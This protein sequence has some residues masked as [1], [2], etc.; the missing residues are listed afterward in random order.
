MNMDKELQNTLWDYIIIG[1][2]VGGSTLG[3]AL[4]KKGKK[5]LFIEKGASEDFI[6]GRFPESQLSSFDHFSE[7]DL[8]LLK[9][10]GRYSDFVNEVSDKSIKRFVPL[11][12]QGLGGS[13]LIYGAALERF[14][15]EDFKPTQ[16]FSQYPN[17]SVVDWPISYPDMDSYYAQAEQLYN[18][19][20]SVDPL[21]KDYQNK[22]LVYTTL[23][24]P[25][26]SLYEYCTK[27]GLHPYRLPVGHSAHHG[28]NCK[29]C[30]AFICETGEK[31]DA[32]KV[33]VLSAIDN[34]NVFLIDCCEVKEINAVKDK[35]VSL[36]AFKNNKEYIFK[37]KN[38]VLAAGTLNTTKLLLSS[39]SEYWP[40]G[41]ANRSG[42][43]G[44]NLSRHFLDLYM[45]DINP[46]D[47]CDYFE[48]EIGLNDFY[49]YQGRK[50]GTIQSLGNPPGYKTALFE[51]HSELA[52]SH[53][54]IDRWYLQLVKWIGRP[55]MESLFRNKLCIATIMDDVSYPENRLYLSESGGELMLTYQMHEEA[56]Q[57]LAEFRKLILKNFRGLSPQ[58]HKQGENNQRLGHATGTCRMGNDPKTS[59][60][61]KF[62]RAH[63]VENLFIVDA[64][65]F[66]SGS[67]INPA[68]TIAANAL[69]VAESI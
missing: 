23:S 67:G 28:S 6:K 22:N 39:K 13:S 33:C 46:L 57:R 31:S 20:G 69:R 17:T 44:R 15:P 19:I 29:G 36:K 16:F 62:N 43:V 52:M 8:E 21:R 60:L 42:Q 58:L 18:V 38:Y 3:Y 63:D 27:N 49:I 68:L 61:N 51:M 64:S 11:L 59:V 56:K 1:T 32:G 41:L 34:E 65:F 10:F 30:Q 9:K 54:A 26:A 35:I 45:I 25:G 66:P 53:R 37:A 48:K 7:S 50:Y 12:G 2:G 5:I 47:D 55:I 40:T 4:A 14:F 24:K